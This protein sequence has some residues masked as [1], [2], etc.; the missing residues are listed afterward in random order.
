MKRAHLCVCVC[1]CVCVP[2]YVCAHKSVSACLYL[3]VQC[4]CVSAYAHLTVC[5][6][7]PS[8]CQIL[9]TQPSGVSSHFRVYC[10]EPTV[11]FMTDCLEK[12]S[13]P[14]VPALAPAGCGGRLGLV[15]LSVVVILQCLEQ[16]AWLK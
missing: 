9:G 3:L 2:I 10:E 13:V 8:G 12:Y 5:V 14:G 7:A 15:L 1:L 11:P 6:C 4:A 16:G